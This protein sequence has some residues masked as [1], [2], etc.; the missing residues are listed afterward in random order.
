VYYRFVASGTAW[1]KLK[2][3]MWEKELWLFMSSLALFAAQ[4]EILFF[5]L[6]YSQI[7]AA[8]ISLFHALSQPERLLLNGR[9][10]HFSARST[11]Y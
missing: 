3:E 9:F 7:S 1:K 5:Y 8:D 2:I 4:S 10:F 6:V 11:S